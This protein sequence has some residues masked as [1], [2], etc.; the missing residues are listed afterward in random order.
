MCRVENSVMEG[1][2]DVE[3]CLKGD[4]FWIELKCEPRPA[5]PS[6]RIK[7]R[8]ERAQLPW[9]NRRTGAGGR[10]FVLLQVGQGHA[11]CRYLL[12]PDECVDLAEVGM[13]EHWLKAH[14]LIDPK[15]PALA[16]VKFAAKYGN[17]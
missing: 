12:P 2:G 11:A 1:M 5:D 8:F 3:G 13:T 14:S 6:T 7:P 17:N 10:A 9:L 4:Q 15:S 16:I